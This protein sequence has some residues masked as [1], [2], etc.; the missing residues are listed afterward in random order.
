VELSDLVRAVAVNRWRAR[1]TRTTRFALLGGALLALNAA[2]AGPSLTS[3]DPTA[4][5]LPALH[6]FVPPPADEGAVRV[7]ASTEVLIEVAVARGWVESDPVI[8][9]RLIRNMGFLEPEGSPEAQFERAVGMGM[10]RR[11]AVVRQRLL[12]R[13]HAELEAPARQLD[14]PEHVLDAFMRS[15]PEQFRRADALRFEQLFF[16]QRERALAAL[17][18]IQG[19]EHAAETIGALGEPFLLDTGPRWASARDLDGRYG[20]DFADLVLAGDDG[21]WTGPVPSSFGWHLTR[22][23]EREEG[24]LPELRD[25]RARVLAAYRASRRHELRRAGIEALLAGYEVVVV[26][27]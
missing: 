10:H 24:G 16:A 11:D 8:R 19:G 23:L 20:A 21:V 9:D 5:P 26:Q 15:E 18:A 27:R 17:A 22:V 3:V 4:A 7:R 13:M 14:P 2:L 25:V 1:L 6:V 12:S